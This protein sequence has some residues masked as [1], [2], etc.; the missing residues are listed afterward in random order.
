MS[1]YNITT[2]AW[3]TG[4]QVFAAKLF[5][6]FFRYMSKSQALKGSGGKKIN[7][8]LLSPWGLTWGFA[9]KF[10]THLEN[11]HIRHES[12]IYLLVW[13]PARISVWLFFKLPHSCRTNSLEQTHWEA[14]WFEKQTIA[15]I[16]TSVWERQERTGVFISQTNIFSPVCRLQQGASHGTAYDSLCDNTISQEDAAGQSTE[17]KQW[18]QRV[19]IKLSL[20]ACLVMDV[21]DVVSR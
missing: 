9:H 17:N 10:N 19:E 12:G 11:T 18:S 2:F 1:C 3:W 20:S 21:L 6:F 7:T 4:L 16:L 15:C 5:I 8:S 13:L 14:V